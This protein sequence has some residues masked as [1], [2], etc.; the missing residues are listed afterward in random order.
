MK[1]ILIALAF[2]AAAFAQQPAD[3]APPY[4]ANWYGAGAAYNRFAAPQINGFASYAHLLSFNAL[5]FPIF[6]FTSMDVS[7]VSAK[8]FSA[9]TSVRSGIATVLKRKGPLFLMGLANAG[10]ATAGQATGGAFSG[11][12][13]L[14]IAPVKTKGWSL[15]FGARV[16][17]TSIGGTQAV[18]EFGIGRSYK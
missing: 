7:S 9:Q 16:L 1:F 14:V 4:P 6:S 12:G 13:M 3:V 5:K 18:Y 17:H 15:I 11:G 8:H 10:V 2:S